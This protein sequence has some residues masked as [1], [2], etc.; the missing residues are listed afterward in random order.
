MKF[1]MVAIIACLICLGCE[2]VTLKAKKSGDDSYSVIRVSHRDSYMDVY[3]I[4]EKPEGI[5]VNAKDI[6]K[7]RIVDL[8]TVTV[9]LP[10]GYKVEKIDKVERETISGDITTNRLYIHV[11]H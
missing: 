5:V 6:K 4:D 11:S 10:K 8:G 9:L 1:F 2:P 3:T 7:D